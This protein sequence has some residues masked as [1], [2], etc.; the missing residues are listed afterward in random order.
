V[1]SVAC[2]VVVFVGF[3][4]AKRLRRSEAGG[5]ASQSRKQQPSALAPGSPG[6]AAARPVSTNVSALAEIPG[7]TGA[8]RVVELADRAPFIRDVGDLMEGA[9]EVLRRC[10]P[11]VVRNTDDPYVFFELSFVLVPDDELYRLS[12]VELERSTRELSPKAENCLKDAIDGT[13]AALEDPP[14]GR[15]SYPLCMH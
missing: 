10:R 15:M 12:S 1:I 13:L 7:R 2:W 6:G 5:E 4:A 14:H 11:L 9:T 3:V 8:T